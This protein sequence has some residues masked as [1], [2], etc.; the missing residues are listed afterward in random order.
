MLANYLKIALRSIARHRAY[1][2]INIFGLSLGIACCLLLTLYVLDERQYDQHHRDLNRLYRI[3]T[4]F[5]SEKGLDKLGTTSPPIAM[6]MAEEIPE[7]ETAARALN[8]PGVA[9]NLIRYNDKSFYEPF[10]YIA[11]STLFDVLTYSF[12]EGDPRT[13][14][15]ESNS[16]VLTQPLAE[17]LFGQETA[18]NKL[19]AISQG[20]PAEQYKVTGVVKP[21]T[22][23]FLTINFFISMTSSTGMAAYMRS[24]N[25]QNEW[26]GQN[27]VPAFVKLAPG[28]TVAEVER[29]MN[30]LLIKYGSEDLKAMGIEK[31]LYLEPVADIYLKSDVGQKPRITYLQVV[32]AIALFLL[33]IACINFVNLATAKATRRATEVGIRKVM[34]AFRAA[35]IQQ[36][37]GEAIVIVL[38][39]VLIAITLT[40][41]ALPLFNEITGKQVALITGQSARIALVLTALT[42]LTGILAGSYPAFYLSSFQPARVLKGKLAPNSAGWLRQSLVVFQFIVAVA[43]LS[44]V[45]VV[46]QQLSFMQTRS[47]GFESG[48]RLIV[49]LRTEQAREAYEELQKELRKQSFVKSVSGVDYTPA[50]QIWNDMAFYPSGGSMEKSTLL[51]RN[52]VDI[53]YLEMMGFQPIAGRLFNENRA[54]E[55]KGKMVINRT[56]AIDLG[57]TPEQAVG[58]PLYFEWQGEKYTFEI[59]GV[60][61]DYHQVSLKEKIYPIVFELTPN[62]RQLGHLIVQLEGNIPDALPTIERTWRAQVEDTPFEY[63]FLDEKVRQQYGEDRKISQVVWIFGSMAMI[64]CCLG[65]Y[66]LSSYMAERRFKEIGVRKVMGASV[67]QIVSMMSGEFARLVT[68]AIVVALPLSWYALNRWL[69]GFAYHIDLD[70][71]IFFTASA[72]ALVLAMITVS[73]ESLKAASVNPALSLK[74]E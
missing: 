38:I 29:K 6:T 69:E 39:S 21:N 28:A 55:S 37:M 50:A 56:G 13:A 15:R 63:S 34:G 27:F 16:V 42:L 47:L 46:S 33:V 8:P 43:L 4:Q 1:T 35:L 9:Q 5:L 58:Q 2:A 11:D 19:I 31:R 23:S 74:N 14:L 32:G 26:A 57:F 25:A 18:V 49:P 60:V 45:L 62:P 36:F 52:T 48:N 44:A 54:A 51:R 71:M 10:G 59:I 72:M 53:G 68:V 12:I 73:F 65:L 41:L 66:G 30:M 17:K 22:R 20:G 40:Q 7:I 70:V 67:Y 3:N 24:D 64:I 61:E